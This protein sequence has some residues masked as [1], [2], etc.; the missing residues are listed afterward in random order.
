MRKALK[1]AC[2]QH[3]CHP[4]LNGGLTHEPSL[5]KRYCKLLPEMMCCL[6]VLPLYPCRYT[7]KI[8]CSSTLPTFPLQWFCFV[9]LHHLYVNLSTFPPA[10]HADAL[11]WI[12]PSVAYEISG[13]KRPCFRSSACATDLRRRF[14]YRSLLRARNGMTSFQVGDSAHLWYDTNSTS[15]DSIL[16]FSCLSRAG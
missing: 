1:T 4:N 3:I 7:K 16:S 14:L 12:P 9:C 11:S 13:T 8:P 5:S 10:G 2:R 6:N 15:V